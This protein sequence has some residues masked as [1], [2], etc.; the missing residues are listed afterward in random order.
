MDWKYIMFEA[1][2]SKLPVIFPPSVIHS[3]MAEG[4]QH[5]IRRHVIDEAPG[6]WSSKPISAGFIST[7]LVTGVHG[8]SETLNLKSV[9][10]DRRIINEWPYCAGRDDGIPCEVHIIEAVRRSFRE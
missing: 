8:D 10:D 9:E 5:S 1:N 7:L 4:I 3:T 6:R 2:G